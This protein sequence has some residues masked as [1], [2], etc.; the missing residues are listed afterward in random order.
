MVPE[1]DAPKLLDQLCRAIRMR[2]YSIRTEHS[3]C[4]W[5]KRYC[6]FHNL[7]HPLEMGAPEINQFL[8]HLATDRNVAASTQNQ[9]C[10]AIVFLYKHVL[11][12]DPG[13]FGD[14]VR[15]KRPK[16]LPVVLSLDETARLL[17]HMT[18]VQRI[19]AELMYATGARIIELVRLRVKDIDFERNQITIREGKGEKDRTVPL[20][21]ELIDDLKH[22]LQRVKKRHDQD[23]EEGFGEVF[24]PHAL[25]RKYP[26]A[27]KEWCWQYLF[28]S[29]IRSTDPRSGTVRRHHVYASVLR[30]AIREATR[31]AEIPKMVHAHALRHSFATHLLEEGHDIRTVQ[32]LLGHA[33]V[34]TTQIYTH[35]T[36][37]GPQAVTT[38]LTRARAAMRNQ[39]D[40]RAT[41]AENDNGLIDI[42]SQAFSRIR[43][44]IGAYISQVQP[45]VHADASAG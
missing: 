34:R 14:V 20:P 8:S 36:Q 40:S 31:K 38:P 6:H 11:Q 15:A 1:A 3:Y 45:S 25:A 41:P 17:S 22:Q 21:S 35:V 7:R 27:A 30:K 18:S 28:P 5:V 44:R 32:E 13:E 33:D 16:K 24:L 10:C 12:K 23:L 37:N 42:L 26:N 29:S 43:E 19:M 39:D 9:A 2:H 4:E